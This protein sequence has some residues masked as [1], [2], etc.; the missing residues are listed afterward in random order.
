M[1]I[2]DVQKSTSPAIVGNNVLA[3]GICRHSNHIIAE[4]EFYV[5]QKKPYSGT[6]LICKKCG[7]N[8]FI[9]DDKYGVY[10]CR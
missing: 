8:K 2:I 5:N 4:R 1:N 3:A 7:K 10:A 6:R 9:K